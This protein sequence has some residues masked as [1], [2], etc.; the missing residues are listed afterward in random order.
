MGIAIFIMALVSLHH[1][2]RQSL[3]DARIISLSTG[4]FPMPESCGLGRDSIED[5]IL[6]AAPLETLQLNARQLCPR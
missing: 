3:E 4:S 2:R 6:R 5:G 1:R